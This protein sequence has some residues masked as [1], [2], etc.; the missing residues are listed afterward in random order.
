MKKK[1]LL[2]HPGTQH[3]FFLAKELYKQGLLYQFHSSLAF[4]KDMLQ[5]KAISFFKRMVNKSFSIESRVLDAVPARMIRAYPWLE[6]SAWNQKRKGELNNNVFFERNRKFQQAIP[7]KSLQKADAVIGFDTSSFVLVDR[8]HALD[9]RFFLEQTIGH[10]ASAVKLSRQLA[11]QFPGWENSWIEKPQRDIDNE[12]HE[13]EQADIIVVPSQFV[14]NTLIENGIDR[15]KILVNPFGTD[16][17]VFFPAQKYPSPDPLIFLFV[18]SISVRKGI[19]L[20][21]KAWEQLN[22]AHAELWIAGSGKIPE[23]QMKTLLPSIKLLGRINRIDMPPL[24]RKAHVFVF[25]SYFEGLAIAQLEAA[26][27]GLPIIGTTASGANEIVEEGKTG[28]IIQPGDLAQL[29]SAMDK[30]LK[31][32]GTA[33]EMY[34]NA[35]EKCWKWDWRFYGERW[36]ELINNLS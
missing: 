6:I 5:Y 8:V 9:K 20:L 21:L 14:K 34:E 18:G 31:D 17:R 13:H 30:F 2:A 24:L 35:K 10:P 11:D 15:S 29:V 33:A 26:A 32:P 1:T 22:P 27:S 3:S 12:K 28:F 36:Q 25:P 7:K 4:T 23:L 16:T 19:P